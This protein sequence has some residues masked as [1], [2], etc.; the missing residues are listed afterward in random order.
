MKTKFITIILLAGLLFA[1]D[2]T[3]LKEAMEIGGLVTLDAYG[4]VNQFEH[5]TF[6]IGSVYL[7]ANL[8][9]SPEVTAS[10]V[11]AA[12]SNLSELWI[13]QALAVFAPTG[14]AWSITAGQ[15]TLKHGLLSTRLICD[16]LILDIVELIQPAITVDYTMGSWTPSLAL[17]SVFDSDT[18]PNWAGVAVIDYTNEEFIINTVRISSLISEKKQ[19]INLG[20]T[21]VH[22]KFTLDAEVYSL[23][24]EENVSLTS[25]YFAGLAFQVTEKLSCAARYDAISADRFKEKD[26]R[27]CFGAIYNIRDGIFCAAEFEHLFNFDGTTDNRLNM[28]IGLENT[29]KLPGFHRET[30]IQK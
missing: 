26:Q 25:G 19:D 16:P 28:Q 29:I 13:D 24:G 5:A 11:V 27:I 23:L 18:M 30:L 6:E 12:E 20:L 15:Q 1:N 10:V 8:T 7:G 21:L 2:S 3:S 4:P 17:T 14:S 22:S 9:L